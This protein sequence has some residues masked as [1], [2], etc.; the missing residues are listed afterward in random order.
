MIRLI[1]GLIFMST[2]VVDVFLSELLDW[3]ND[4]MQWSLNMW[5]AETPNQA[6]IRKLPPEVWL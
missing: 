5:Y 4:R 3:Y 2:I 1:G 6:F